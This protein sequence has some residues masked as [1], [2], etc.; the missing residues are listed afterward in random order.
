MHGIRVLHQEAKEAFDRQYHRHE[1][2][3]KGLAADEL[4]PILL[5]ATLQA[6]LIFP[7]SC[8]HLLELFIGSSY[9]GEEAYFLVTLEAI[10]THIRKTPVCTPYTCV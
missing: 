10:I 6:R 1:S 7:H 9:G 3:F 8:L 4:F 2:S 5:Y